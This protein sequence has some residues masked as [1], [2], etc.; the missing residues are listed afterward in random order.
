LARAGILFLS[1]AKAH[2]RKTFILI[3]D[4]LSTF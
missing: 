2:T 3:N 4:L 1:K